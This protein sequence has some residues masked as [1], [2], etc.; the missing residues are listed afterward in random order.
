MSDLVGNTE[1]RFSCVAAQ[2]R[3]FLGSHNVVEIKSRSCYICF[4]RN[5]TASADNHVVLYTYE[6]INNAIENE[7]EVRF[8]S[9]LLQRFFY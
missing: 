9:F 6:P 7:V 3:F 2:I 8:S 5:R 1:D 4:R